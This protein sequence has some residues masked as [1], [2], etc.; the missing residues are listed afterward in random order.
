MRLRVKGQVGKGARFVWA[1]LD[2]FLC[3]FVCVCVYVI[4]HPFA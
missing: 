3:Q 1:G 4:L 2:S